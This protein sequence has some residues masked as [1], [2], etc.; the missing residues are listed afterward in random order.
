M[1]VKSVKFQRQ[2]HG[3]PVSGHGPGGVP[4]DLKAGWAVAV[5]RNKIRGCSKGV[6]LCMGGY[7]CIMV[8]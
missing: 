8:A 4:V 2:I 1:I 6:G 5:P 3:Q 7:V